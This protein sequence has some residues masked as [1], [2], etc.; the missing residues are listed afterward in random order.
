VDVAAWLR[1]LGLER[2]APAFLGAKI[3]PEALPELTDADLRDLGLPL[4]SRKVVLGAIQVLAGLPPEPVGINEEAA[5]SRAPTAPPQAERRQLIVTVVD[6]AG[7]T[8]LSQR[9]D[10][11]EMRDVHQTCKDAAQVQNPRRHAWRLVMA[12]KIVPAPETTETISRPARH[13][14]DTFGN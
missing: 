12:R 10:P 5:P 1:D 13:R 3:T 8:A 6:L 4:G 14:P 7:S 9:L 2:H 11:E